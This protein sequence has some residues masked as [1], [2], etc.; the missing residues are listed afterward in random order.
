MWRSLIS[1]ALLRLHQD[2]F[3]NP[4]APDFMSKVS[5]I[6]LYFVYLAIASFVAGYLQVDEGVQGR[7]THISFPTLQLARS[8]HVLDVG[9]QPASR[10][11]SLA[12]PGRRAAAGC[13]VL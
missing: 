5:Q 4:S 10:Q 2:T 11:A 1:S 3:G 7:P 9:G 12:V 8:G 13:R 6:A